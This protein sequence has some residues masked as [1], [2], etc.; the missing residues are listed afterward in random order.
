MYSCVQ[1]TL[2]SV[3]QLAA[4]TY[5]AFNKDGSGSRDSL[6]SLASQLSLGTAPAAEDRAQQ[7]SGTVSGAGGSS[8][9]DLVSFGSPAAAVTGA[10]PA[11]GSSASSGQFFSLGEDDDP[12]SLSNSNSPTKTPTPALNNSGMYY[13]IISCYC[14]QMRV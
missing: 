8:S 6:N 3:N 12:V 2:D 7:D 4:Q 11:G 10:A 13:Y 1:G 14:R 5:S 9:S